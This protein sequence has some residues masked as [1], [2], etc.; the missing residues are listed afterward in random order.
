MTLSRPEVL[1]SVASSRAAPS[2]SCP[3]GC[4]PLQRM[5]QRSPIGSSEGQQPVPSG[6]YYRLAPVTPFNAAPQKL[7]LSAFS[8]M[9]C[10][11]ISTLVK[12][13]FFSLNTGTNPGSEESVLMKCCRSAG[14][15]VTSHELTDG[16]RKALMP[17]TSTLK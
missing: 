7:G 3:C 15:V 13:H 6:G 16:T 5:G 12:Q 9:V 14:D 17:P 4:S 10:L 8:H 2:L 1:F 11:S